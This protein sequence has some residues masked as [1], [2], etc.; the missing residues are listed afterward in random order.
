MSLPNKANNYLVPNVVVRSSDGERSYDIESRLLSDR[1]IVLKGEV[2]DGMAAVVVEELIHLNNEHHKR[3]IHMYIMSP[4]G[5]VHAGLAIIDAMKMI[6]APVYT[7][8]MGFTVSMGAAILSAGDKRFAWPNAQIMV[9]QM[10]S[11]TEGKVHDIVVDSNYNKRLNNLLLAMIAHNCKRLSDKE[12][13]E[14]FDAV[15]MMID[16]TEEPT[17]KV[18]PTTKK[19]LDKFKEEI[20]RDTWLFPKAALK[21]GIIDEILSEK[22]KTTSQEKK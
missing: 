19:K 4:G 16:D 17:F 9:H 21:F 7:Y 10:A 5:S 2:E 8:A 22:D 18:S 12:Y 20:D 11:G 3:P 1:I 14:I 13:N 6:E 15:S